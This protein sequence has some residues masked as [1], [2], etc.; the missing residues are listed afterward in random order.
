[1]WKAGALQLV[2]A[3]DC[4]H[5]PCALDVRGIQMFMTVLSGSRKIRWPEGRN[6][7]THTH[8]SRWIVAFEMR[9]GDLPFPTHLAPP[10]MEGKKK[11]NAVNRCSRKKWKM[12]E[13]T[14]SWVHVSI[15]TIWDS[16]QT[17]SMFKG[18]GE[19]PGFCWQSKWNKSLI[20]KV[21]TVCQVRKSPY[22]WLPWGFC[23]I[24]L[25]CSLFLRKSHTD[26][27]GEK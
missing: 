20:R 11:P 8:K 7:P 15:E 4:A 19:N 27:S 17:S 9:R 18:G 26:F 16:K 13:D 6:K 12:L 23:S 1:M 14:D 3:S 21:W 25:L 24:F 5:V 10:K 22:R 2:G